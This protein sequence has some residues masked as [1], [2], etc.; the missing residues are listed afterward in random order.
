MQSHLELE[1]ALRV[2]FI[3]IL[4]SD[5]APLCKVESGGMQEGLMRNALLQSDGISDQGVENAVRSDGMQLKRI[6]NT[7]MDLF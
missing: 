7:C 5:V 1:A 2:C 3:H 6:I 4:L